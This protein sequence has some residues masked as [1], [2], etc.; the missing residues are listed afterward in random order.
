MHREGVLRHLAGLPG[1]LPLARVPAEGSAYSLA[2]NWVR[3]APWLVAKAGGQG[4]EGEAERPV[5]AVLEAA[6]VHLGRADKQRIT[7]CKGG[8]QRAPTPGR[9]EGLATLPAERSPAF[10]HGHSGRSEGLAPG[11][12]LF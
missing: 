2:P 7:P 12:L 6:T 10:L 4:G 1:H 3:P 11:R 5:H 9:L 8:L